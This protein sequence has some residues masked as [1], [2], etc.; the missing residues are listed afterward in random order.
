MN[1]HHTLADYFRLATSKSRESVARR[2][3]SG[4]VVLSA[5][6][7]R[8]LFAMRLVS[9]IGT[10]K[11]RAGSF[12]HGSARRAFLSVRKHFANKLRP[13]LRCNSF[14]RAWCWRAKMARPRSLRRRRGPGLLFFSA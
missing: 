8:V 7:L 13:L 3:A 1:A 2:V 14:G 12:L 5:S 9:R 10:G 6:A 4:L 11:L